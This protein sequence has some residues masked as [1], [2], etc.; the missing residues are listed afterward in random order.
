[1]LLE[2][3]CGNARNGTPPW[4]TPGVT[5]VIV[6]VPSEVAITA[7]GAAVPGRFF[8]PI[9]ATYNDPSAPTAIEVTSRFDVS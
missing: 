5:F 9:A 7:D 4:T 3:A 6:V 1:M 8:S 2:I